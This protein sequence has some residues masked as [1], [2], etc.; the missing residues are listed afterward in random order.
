M[1][2]PPTAPPPGAPA[3]RHASPAELARLGIRRVRT[4]HFQVGR[5]R[6]ANLADALAA[7]RRAPVP[8]NDR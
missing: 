2:V 7:A 8:G 6:Y 4:E 1:N 5:Y 3:S